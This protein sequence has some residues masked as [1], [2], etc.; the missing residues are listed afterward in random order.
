MARLTRKNIKVFAGNATDNGV[1]GSLQANNPT[2]TSDVEQIQSLSAWSDGWNSATETSE[3][4]PPLEEFQGVQYVT[5]YQQ[6]YLMQEGIPEWAATVTYYKGCLAKEVTST[7][8]RIYNSLTDNNTGNILSDT[9]NWKKVMD[10]EDLYA[11]DNTVV[12]K[13]GAETIAGT[14]TFASGIISKEGGTHANYASEKQNYLSI[15]AY[16]SA[17]T[18]M[19][20]VDCWTDTSGI[21]M[22]RIVSFDPSDPTN[23]S[24]ISAN[25]DSNGNKSTYAPTPASN[26]NDNNIATTGWVNS[27]GNNVV[28]RSG[29]E[30]IS[31]SKTFTGYV[32]LPY[33]TLFTKQQANAIEG[34]QLYLEKPQNTSLT[35]NPFIDM[36]GNLLRFVGRNSSNNYTNPLFLDLETNIAFAT[37]SDAQ[38]SVV[39]TTGISKSENGFVKLGNGI[40]IQWG[41]YPSYVS[42]DPQRVTFPTPFTSTNYKAVCT[43]FRTGGDVDSGKDHIN[44]DTQF[45][46]GFTFRMSDTAAYGVNW[47]AIGY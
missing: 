7:G 46:T 25:V 37:P 22:T 38:N 1:F 32:S 2:T 45:T 5:T 43:Y 33:G 12:H 40:I 28:H 44:V 42:P 15:D 8:F 27:V 34:G 20:M 10:S 36:Y 18:P 30:N 47:I 6:A 9:S 4:L 17:D 16:D 21:N 23:Y 24:V 13:A 11:F 3:M 26:S 19:G 39:T 14:K 41:R 35:L 29:N 31:G